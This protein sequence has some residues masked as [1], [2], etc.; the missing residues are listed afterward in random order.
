MSNPTNVVMLSVSEATLLFGNWQ[1]RIPEY[2]DKTIVVVNTKRHKV[3]TAF[4][5]VAVPVRVKKECPTCA[6]KGKIDIKFFR[7][8]NV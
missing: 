4:K 2:K 8:G 3:V 5:F 7:G 6:G 1:E